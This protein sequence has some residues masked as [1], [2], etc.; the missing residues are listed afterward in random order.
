MLSFSPRVILVRGRSMK[1]LGSLDKF[2][3]NI[4]T[5]FRS[6]AK[7]VGTLHNIKKANKNFSAM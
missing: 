3:Y 1:A 4:L 5:L 7:S 2:Q 6:H